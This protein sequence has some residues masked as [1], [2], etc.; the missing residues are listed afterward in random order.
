[1]WVMMEKLIPMLFPSV[2]KN[3]LVRPFGRKLRT[4]FVRVHAKWLTLRRLGC[5]VID[6]GT[7][8]RSLKTALYGPSVVNYGPNLFGSMLNG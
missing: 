4:R 2:A 3:G 5:T 8:L 7:F 1:M 6:S